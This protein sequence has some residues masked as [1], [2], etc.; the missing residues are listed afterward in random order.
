MVPHFSKSIENICIFK[1]EHWSQGKFL[2]IHCYSLIGT[3]SFVFLYYVILSTILLRCFMINDDKYVYLIVSK[4]FIY[5]RCK[6]ISH[7]I[8][9][10]KIQECTKQVTFCKLQ[11]NTQYL[12]F[13]LLI[14]FYKQIFQSFIW[15]SKIHL[16]LSNGTWMWQVTVIYFYHRPLN[17]YNS[18]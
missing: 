1:P 12:Q 13:N 11:L 7:K 4:Q 3:N 16:Q 17:Y 6:E 2:F 5:E 18:F 10:K 9:F 8:I 15:K 14:H